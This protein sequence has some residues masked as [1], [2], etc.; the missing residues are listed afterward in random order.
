MKLLIRPGELSLRAAPADRCS[1]Q[2]HKP[3]ILQLSGQAQHTL[4]ST[5][6]NGILEAE[7]AYKRESVKKLIDATNDLVF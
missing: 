4:K 3:D 5:F 6:I 7:A 2:G 1:G